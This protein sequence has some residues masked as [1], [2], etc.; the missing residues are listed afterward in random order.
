MSLWKRANKS[1]RMK[2]RNLLS[3]SNPCLYPNQKKKSKRSKKS[4]KK[5][6]TTMKKRK[7]RRARK[8]LRKKLKRPKR[9]LIV[10]RLIQSRN[11]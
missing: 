5:A 6:N 10:V 2:R 1:L 3:R 11:R 4:P 9:R 7:K 8:R